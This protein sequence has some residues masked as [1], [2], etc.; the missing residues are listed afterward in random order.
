MFGLVLFL[1]GLCRFRR[2]VWFYEFCVGLGCAHCLV[3]S[4]IRFWAGL[5]H[6]PCFVWF[7]VF[8]DGLGRSRCVCLV[9]YG[10]G[11]V[12]ADFTVLFGFLTFRV[13]LD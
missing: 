5:C 4:F 9:L 2:F 12:S 6:V 7:S 10:F 1:A 13:G 11:L 8:C 3:L